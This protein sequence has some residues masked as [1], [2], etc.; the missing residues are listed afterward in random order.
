[1]LNYSAG[2]SG[3]ARGSETE[4]HGTGHGGAE[5]GLWLHSQAPTY[6]HTETHTHTHTEEAFLLVGQEIFQTLQIRKD[7]HGHSESEIFQEHSK[8]K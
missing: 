3:L 8:H 2:L 4:T 6:S 7:T 5:T 1:M